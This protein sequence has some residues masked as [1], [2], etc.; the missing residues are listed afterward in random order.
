MGSK[1]PRA[2]EDFVDTL[3]LLNDVLADKIE[4]VS[5]ALVDIKMETKS[6]Q[7]LEHTLGES[8]R[9]NEKVASDTDQRVAK[10]A[11]IVADVDP[12]ANVVGSANRANLERDGSADMRSRKVLEG[13]GDAF[14]DPIHVEEVDCEGQE[15]QAVRRGHQI[16]S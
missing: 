8:K 3:G 16:E 2:R 14:K 6:I 7:L 11:G 5:T 1:L 12:G 15:G 13:D 4:S 10:V 9:E